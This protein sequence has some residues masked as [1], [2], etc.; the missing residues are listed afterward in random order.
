MISNLASKIFG[1]RNERIIKRHRKT[2]DAI[3]KLEPDFEEACLH[4]EKNVTA[5]N[6]AST[7]QIREKAHTRSVRRWTRYEKQLQSL[8]EH[9]ERAGIDTG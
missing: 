3:N 1:S 2:V 9:L 8:Q 4:F 6:T 5:S 7:V